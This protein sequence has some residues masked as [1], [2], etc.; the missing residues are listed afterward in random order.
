MLMSE[1]KKTAA[2]ELSGLEDV[3]VSEEKVGKPSLIKS[4]RGE[5]LGWQDSL[6]SAWARFTNALGRN[7]ATPWVWS[8]LMG[9]I[10]ALATVTDYTPGN[11][12]A[13][14]LGLALIM[15]L[16]IRGLLRVD[17][18][19]LGKA[20]GHSFMGDLAL[21]GLIICGGAVLTKGYQIFVSTFHPGW[22]NIHPAALALGAPFAA[23]PILASFFLGM[24]AGLFLA[25]IA[26]FSASQLWSEHSFDIALFHFIIC[27]YGVY[28]VHGSQGRM[29][30]IRTGLLCSLVALPLLAGWAVMNQVPVAWKTLA[31]AIGFIAGPLSGVLAAGLMPVVE[32]L[33]HSTDDRMRAMASLDHPAM[34]DLM[35]N[36]PGTYHHSLVVSSLVEA[37]ARAI[38]ADHLLARTAALYHDL[39]KMKKPVYFVENFGHEPN[40]H[41]KLAPSMSALILISH[42]K[43]GVDLA[44][45]YRLSKA[46][47]DIILQHHGNRVIS[48]FYSK[49]CE[50]A[51]MA[52][53]PEPTPEHFRYPGPKPQTREAGLVML[54][55]IVEAA[56]RTLVNPTP[57]RLQGLVKQQI[58]TC[59]AEGQMDECE[60][61]LKDLHNI[62]SIFN[63]ILSGIYHSRVEYPEEKK[64][65]GDNHKQ[66]AKKLAP[67]PNPVEGAYT[68]DANL[69]NV[70]K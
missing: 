25:I 21:L 2:L 35:L 12:Q 36:A 50:S 24:R 19:N 47:Q 58:N 1:K 18:L 48:Y 40:R 57:A 22:L 63:T 39:G 11:W 6:R 4:K 38:G 54:A 34:R 9:T 68:Q 55:D 60:L 3:S 56:S 51:R 70:S 53:M 8:V 59:F 13:Y 64:A 10:V 41:D 61:T 16:M 5:S 66:P 15:I 14:G 37:A 67:V 52:G 7:R 26:S 28:M 29:R 44:R 46:V 17:F 23:A 42:V 20:A 30:I 49:A 62:A 65:N 31:L 45:K 43:D 69:L 33:G 32:A 27:L